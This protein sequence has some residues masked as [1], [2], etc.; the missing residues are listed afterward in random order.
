MI[1]LLSSLCTADP[2]IMD[3]LHRKQPNF[4]RNRSGVWKIVDFRPL[5]R[6]ISE[7][8]QDGVH[9]LLLTSNRNMYTH[10]RWVPKSMTLD[11]LEV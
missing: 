8:V 4:S 9:K 7:T 11:D 1:S 2:N 3:I 6:R 5:S 10:F